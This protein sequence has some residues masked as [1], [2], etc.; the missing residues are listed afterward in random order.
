VYPTMSVDIIA[1]SLRSLW[2]KASFRSSI[3]SRDE[4]VVGLSSVVSG[5]R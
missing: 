5:I 3:E 1:A 2:D 4:A